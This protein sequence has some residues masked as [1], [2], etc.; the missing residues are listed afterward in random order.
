MA[1]LTVASHNALTPV[2]YNPGKV[3]VILEADVVVN[4]PRLA[5]AFLV[6]F[7]LICALH[8]SYPEGL[9]STFEFI[10]NILLGLDECKLSHRLQTLKND[11]MICV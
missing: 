3:S 7:S 2:H 5:D 10:Q 6:M 9:T 8:L 4:L 11:W 1:L